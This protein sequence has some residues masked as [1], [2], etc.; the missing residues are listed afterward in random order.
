MLQDIPST[1]SSSAE[2]TFVVEK[3]LPPDHNTSE[4]VLR[5]VTSRLDSLGGQSSVE[6]V[7]R[8]VAEAA[9]GLDS[10]KQSCL[11]AKYLLG[12]QRPKTGLT[13]VA[14]PAAPVNNPTA[15]DV[16]QLHLPSFLESSEMDETTV[17]ED[18]DDGVETASSSSSW[19]KQQPVVPD[20]A[21]TSA[22]PRG[23]LDGVEHIDVMSGREKTIKSR[24]ET[25]GKDD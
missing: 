21:E 10:F 16:S 2:S 17:D 11:V 19:H 8:A 14:A 7:R 23:A 24:S 4:L 12:N 22:A 13:P 18:E 1:A 3:S 20:G 25:G 5:E 6:S 15:A 9:P